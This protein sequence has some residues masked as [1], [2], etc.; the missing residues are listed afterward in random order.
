MNGLLSLLL[1][2]VF[3]IYGHALGCRAHMVH[4]SGTERQ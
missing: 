2:A 3:F 1:F 4:G